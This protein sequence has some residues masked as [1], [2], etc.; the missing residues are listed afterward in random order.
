M[1]QWF[2]YV[3]QQ[4]SILTPVHLFAFRPQSWWTITIQVFTNTFIVLCIC[5]EP[6][7]TMNGEENIDLTEQ[8]QS[9]DLQISSNS[10]TVIITMNGTEDEADLTSQQQSQ[11]SSNNTSF[12]KN[13]ELD[14]RKRQLYKCLKI[15]LLSV[16][17]VI[18]VSGLLLPSMIYYF[19][20][21]LVSFSS[22]V[23]SVA[24]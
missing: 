1:Y 17:A 11:E 21:P 4:L 10:I 16:F 19:P 22:S 9:Q 20:L 8:Q 2:W 15:L 6:L 13:Q 18:G 5:H 7:I 23:V 3:K 14:R 12:T 24:Q